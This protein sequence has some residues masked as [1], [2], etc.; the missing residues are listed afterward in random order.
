MGGFMYNDYE[1]ES[2]SGQVEWERLDE[3]LGNASCEED[4]AYMDVEKPLNFG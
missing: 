2:I 4:E 3:Y 1:L